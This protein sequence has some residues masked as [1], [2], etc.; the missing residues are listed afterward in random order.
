[1]QHFRE[2][3]VARLPVVLVGDR[4]AVSEPLGRDVC[5]ELIGQFSCPQILEQLG[6]CSEPGRFN[7]PKQLR[8]Q[9]GVAVAVAGNDR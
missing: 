1:M 5:R 4:R 8:P 6:P 7:D 9:I 2:V 3:L